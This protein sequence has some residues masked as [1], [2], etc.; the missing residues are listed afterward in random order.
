VYSK[1]GMRNSSALQV[2]DIKGR[3]VTKNKF[4]MYFFMQHA[5]TGVTPI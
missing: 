2:T 1:N 5:H 4:V 3:G